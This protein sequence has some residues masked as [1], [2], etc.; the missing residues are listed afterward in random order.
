MDASDHG[1]LHL[2]KGLGLVVNDLTQI[3]NLLV[4]C[5]LFQLELNTQGSSDV[6]TIKDL[7]D[8]GQQVVGL[9]L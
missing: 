9:Y 4:V 7:R 2:F 6:S 1:L 8:W 3:K 5:L